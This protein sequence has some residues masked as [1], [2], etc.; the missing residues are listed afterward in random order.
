MTDFKPIKVVCIKELYSFVPN[1]FYR[2]FDDK[3]PSFM[4]FEHFKRLRV[5]DATQ[6][7]AHYASIRP[8]SGKQEDSMFISAKRFNQHFKVIRNDL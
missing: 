5:Y 7:S 1:G 6:I 2:K 4:A 3:P 8:F